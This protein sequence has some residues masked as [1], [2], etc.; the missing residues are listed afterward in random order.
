M[1]YYAFLSPEGNCLSCLE[2][3][4]QSLENC[5]FLTTLSLRKEEVDKDVY[6][7]NTLELFMENQ[8]N[9]V[10]FLETL[11][12]AKIPEYLEIDL[13]PLTSPEGYTYIWTIKQGP[14]PKLLVSFN[15]TEPALDLNL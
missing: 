4:Y 8:A 12:P 3:S 15:F 5:K 6:S 9:F 11:T 14:I 10:P 1:S 7:S 13:S 2:E